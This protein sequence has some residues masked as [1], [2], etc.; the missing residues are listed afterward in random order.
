VILLWATLSQLYVHLVFRTK[1]KEHHIPSSVLNEL[2][3]YLGGILNYHK[4]PSIIIG[5][6]SDHVHILFRLSKNIALSKIVEE[7]KSSSSKWLK[8]KDDSLK[9]FSWQDGYGAFSID[10]N[11]L[12][13][14]KQYIIN[15]TEHH[16]KIS[17]KDELL[18]FFQKY[19]ID[20][21]EKYVWD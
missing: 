11:Q 18:E 19:D 14:T 16:K 4:S 17:F 20:Y 10:S 6:T 15:Q 1:K 9:F 8:T 21:D 13:K 2:F 5:G 12:E 7:L 3:M